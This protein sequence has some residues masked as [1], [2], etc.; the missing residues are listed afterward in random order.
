MEDESQRDEMNA[1]IRAQRERGAVPRSMLPGEE[2]PPEP[3]QPP[4]QPAPEP[5]PP[6]RGLLG[7]LLGR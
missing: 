7:R 1:A 3:Q 2:E 6:R 4:V 5:G